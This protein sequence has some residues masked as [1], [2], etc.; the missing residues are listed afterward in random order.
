MGPKG[1]QQWALTYPNYLAYSP[2]VCFV[3]CF[4]ESK[5]ETP[6]LTVWRHEQGN[7]VGTAIPDCRDS[8]S[9]MWDTSGWA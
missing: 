6:Y 2:G 3:V 7:A 9:A 5:A 8:C 4:S 1:Q